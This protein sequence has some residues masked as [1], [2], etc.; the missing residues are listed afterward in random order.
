LDHRRFFQHCAAEARAWKNLLDEDA[1]TF[2]DKDFERY[3]DQT[4]ATTSK[5]ARHGE[6][7]DP[8]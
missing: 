7:G 2:N 8:R 6:E 1:V 5:S 4:D 3:R